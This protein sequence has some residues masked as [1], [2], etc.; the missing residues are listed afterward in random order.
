VSIRAAVPVGEL[1]G[2][3]ALFRAF[4]AGKNTPVHRRLGGFGAGDDAWPR[5][6]GPS[7]GVDARLVE[8]LVDENARLGVAQ[9]TLDRLRGLSEGRTR[10]VVT[11]Q[12]PGVACSPLLSL[13]K[14]ATA[15]TLAREI[16][17]RWKTPCVPIFWLGSDDDD[18]PEI[19]ELSVVSEAL[20]VVTVRLDAS[21]HAPGRRVGDIDAGAVAQAWGAVA[22][23]LPASEVTT[24]MGAIMGMGDDLGRSAARALVELT[25]GSIAVVDG[26][27]AML[28]EAARDTILAFFDGEDSVRALVDEGGAAL[29]AEGYHAQLDPGAD[30]GLFLLQ[31]GTRRRIPPDAR[32]TA[33][34]EFARDITIASPGA[35]ARNII[36]DAVLLPVAVVLGPAEI[37]YRAQLSRVYDVLGVDKPVAF[38]RLAATFV[39]PAVR[40]ASLQSGV[41]PVLLATDPG[42]WVEKVKQ[43][44]ENPRVAA[45]ARAF[46]A[47]FRAQSARFA[48]AASERLDPRSKEK[49][50]R[51]IA[52]VAARVESLAQ[53]AAEQD[54]LLGAAQWPWLSRAT[55]LF[56]RD[57]DPQ[58]RYLSAPVPFTFHGRDAWD[59]VFDV[60][61]AHVRDSL[62]GRVLHRVYSR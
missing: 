5:A 54:A 47:A 38:P 57:G 21:A 58:E 30:S 3:T 1:A 22:S 39:P 26:R 10:A 8:R 44:L 48:A 28:R 52:D 24:R 62:D 53:A 43:S 36:Q 31:D 15:V 27:E 6:L 32:A 46:E 35:V 42:R 37:A 49:L 50:E 12:Q 4:V 16:E 51:R 55:E 7:R 34:A 18:F 29:V 23:F 59:L 61:A 60:A 2:S 41:D 33:R 14:A 11:G 56:T 17:A 13:Y 19:R 20:A 25:A 9:S 45:A 40:D